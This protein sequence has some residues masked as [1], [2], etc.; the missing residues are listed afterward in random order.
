MPETLKKA[1]FMIEGSEKA[2]KVMFNPNEYTLSKRVERS[3]EKTPGQD[4]HEKQYLYGCNEK[5]SLKLFFDTYS[6]GEFSSKLP[7]AEKDDVRE[8][9]SRI[10]NLLEKAES[11]HK[12]PKVIFVWGKFRFE[13]YIVSVS[14]RF[15]MFTFK[16]VPVRAHMD[17][18]MEGEQVI[19][20]TQSSPDRTKSHIVM[21]N[22]QLWQLAEAEYDDAG[23][24]REIAEANRID[25]P[26]I[27]KKATNLKIPSL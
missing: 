20:K 26:R 4:D 14:Q 24:W 9:T 11:N 5:L 12:P 17:V 21:E 23:L 25:N 27:L 2:I 7:E 10:Y 16:G 18:E 19:E 1:M 6:T 15:T 8:E 3:E 13:G 22:E